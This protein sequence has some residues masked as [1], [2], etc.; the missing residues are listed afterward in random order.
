MPLDDRFGLDDGQG[1]SP[2]GPESGEPDPEDPVAGPQL[3]AFDGVLVDGNLLPQGEVLGG[4]AEPGYQE[5]SDQKVDRLDDAHGA[6]PGWLGARRFY[7][8]EPQDSKP[9]KSLTGNEYGIIGRHRYG[10]ASGAVPASWRKRSGRCRETRSPADLDRFLGKLRV[11]LI[12][13]QDGS[14][15]WLLDNFPNLFV[16]LSERNYMGMFWNMRGSDPKLADLAWINAHVRQGHGPLGAA[17]PQV[18][19]TR[20]IPGSKREIRLHSCTWSARYAG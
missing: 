10:F 18:G 11:Y 2:V 14:A 9:R 8:Q 3:G 12:A 16:I 15:Q 4:Q 19:S 13:K 17:Y 6:L 7:R 20:K 5:C 1:G